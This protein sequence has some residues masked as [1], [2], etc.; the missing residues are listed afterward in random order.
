MSIVDK[1]AVASIEYRNI[2][3]L[4]SSIC[5]VGKKRKENQDAVL[6]ISTQWSG[7]NVSLFCISDGM[8]GLSEGK[9]AS[10]TCVEGLATWYS[11]MFA[12]YGNDDVLKLDLEMR[13]TTLFEDFRDIH[14][15]LN[16]KLFDEANEMKISM[17]ATCTSLLIIGDT[18]MFV[19]IGDTRLYVKKTPHVLMQLTKDDS[20]AFFDYQQGKISKKAIRRH[21]KRNVLT[22]CMGYASTTKL[23]TG[24][25]TL[26]FDDVVFLC[27]D[28]VHGYCSDRTIEA[29]M[30]KSLRKGPEAG[31]RHLDR[32]I[33][34]T[35]ATDNYSM[36][37]ATY[38]TTTQR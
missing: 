9:H 27:S 34:R 22:R 37:M 35:S 6:T 23:N 11:D 8:G 15:T 36:I 18:Y 5:S 24:C 12:K 21:P 28:G 26:T 13:R 19:H 30:K 25:G 38:R 17:G 4:C 10:N 3:L 31:I 1:M 29:A 7:L 32:I 20:L 16:R 2:N 33:R 14:A